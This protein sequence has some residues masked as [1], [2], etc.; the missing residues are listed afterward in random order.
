MYMT[1]CTSH[2]VYDMTYDVYVHDT[3]YMTHGKTHCILHIVYDTLYM[4][5]LQGEYLQ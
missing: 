5:E 4:M 3:L 1:Y 2:I